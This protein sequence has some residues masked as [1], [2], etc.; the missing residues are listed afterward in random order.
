MHVAVYTVYRPTRPLS[1]CPGLGPRVL[2]SY[3]SPKI[4]RDSHQFLDGDISST[5]SRV[6]HAHSY[7]N[8]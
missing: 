2:A 8:I 7:I 4:Q 6:I 1:H 5:L 3:I